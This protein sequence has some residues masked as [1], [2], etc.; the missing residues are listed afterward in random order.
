M[1]GTTALHIVT[2]IVSRVGLR[3]VFVGSEGNLLIY[4]NKIT[5]LL[6]NK[7]DLK[8]THVDLIMISS[9]S[10]SCYK[11]DCSRFF[12]LSFYI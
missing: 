8:R 1:H 5:R 2:I 9:E 6:L 11:T 7:C 10:H 12:T 4:C 3:R